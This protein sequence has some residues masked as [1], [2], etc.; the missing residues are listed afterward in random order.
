[1]FFVLNSKICSFYFSVN[2]LPWW[3]HASQ[4]REDRHPPLPQV[5]HHVQVPVPALQRA[6]RDQ[7]PTPST[8]AWAFFSKRTGQLAAKI[9]PSTRFLKSP[10]VACFKTQP[11]SWQTVPVQEVTCR[12]R[13]PKVPFLP[14]IKDIWLEENREFHTYWWDLNNRQNVFSIKMSVIQILPVS[15]FNKN[16]S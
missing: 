5:Q 7:S 15:L 3:E 13:H 10:L 4:R 12:P 14:I 2:G 16:L 1:M 8:R 9:H 11:G 6:E